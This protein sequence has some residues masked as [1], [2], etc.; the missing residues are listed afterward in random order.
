MFMYIH[1][2]SYCLELIRCFYKLRSHLS[3]NNSKVHLINASDGKVP[4]HNILNKSELFICKNTWSI[5]GKLSLSNA[6]CIDRTK[7]NHSTAELGSLHTHFGIW[8]M[9]IIEYPSLTVNCRTA[10]KLLFLFFNI[11]LRVNWIIY[12]V[13]VHT[14]EWFSLV[15]SIQNAF[16]SESFHIYC[17]KKYWYLI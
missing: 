9:L 5:P 2:L 13:H 3:V 1:I 4:I 8:V 10:I 7:E 16:D 15:L 11:C 12:Y 14:V 17:L 6:F